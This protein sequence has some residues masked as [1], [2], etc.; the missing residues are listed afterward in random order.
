M[1]C[2]QTKNPDLGKNFR[3]LERQMLL[4]VMAIWNILWPLGIFYGHL[5]HCVFIWYIFPALVSWSKTNLATLLFSRQSK[6]AAG[7]QSC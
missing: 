1:V 3:A 6:G 5:A 4:Y 7:K 2:F